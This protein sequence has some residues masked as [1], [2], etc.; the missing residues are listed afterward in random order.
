MTN[1]DIIFVGDNETI[2]VN[3][4]AVNRAQLE[5]VY[6]IYNR[7]TGETKKPNGCGRCWRNVKQRVHQEYLKKVNIL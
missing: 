4:T 7:I 3:N 6:A 2:F 5:L 1:K